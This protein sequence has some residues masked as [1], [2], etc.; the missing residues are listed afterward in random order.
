MPARIRRDDVVVITA[1][2]DKGKQG[3][4]LKVLADEDRVLVEGINKVT[5]H[6]KANPQNPA[7]GGRVEREA[8]IHISNVMPWSDK[9]KKGVRVRFQD[10]QGKLVRVSAA[11]GAKITAV[12]PAAAEKKADKKKGDE[13]E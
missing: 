2:K 4:V 3:R 13:K 6:R 8:P 9:D 7:E 5:K 11:S 10:E 12:A 1:G